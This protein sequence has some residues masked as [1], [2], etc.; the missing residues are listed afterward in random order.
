MEA[1]KSHDEAE[2]EQ[3]N[4]LKPRAYFKM[5][6]Q[7]KMELAGKYGESEV[8]ERRFGR[9]LSEVHYILTKKLPYQV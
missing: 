2:R 4:P 8:K 3:Q 6:K 1:P 5:K 7:T 9:V